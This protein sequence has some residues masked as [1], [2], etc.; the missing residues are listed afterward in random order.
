MNPVRD[1]NAIISKI[2]FILFLKSQLS[3]GQV[4]YIPLEV[5]PRSGMPIHKYIGLL[6]GLSLTG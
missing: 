5:I 1:N 2:C 6:T 4:I 3:L